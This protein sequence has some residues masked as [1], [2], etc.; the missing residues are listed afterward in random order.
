MPGRAVATARPGKTTSAVRIDDYEAALSMMRHLIALGHRDI[1]FIK[2]DPK[3]TPARLRY[4]AFLDAMREA[5][6]AVPPERVVEGMFTYQSGLAAA[7]TLLEQDQRPSAVFACND[8][9]AAAVL[10]VAHGL[11]LDV[12]EDLAVCGV[13]DTPLATTVWPNLTTVHQPIAEMGQVAVE[14]MCR[15]IRSHRKQEPGVVEHRLLPYKL[16]ARL[17]S[18]A[19]AKRGA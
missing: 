14:L 7:R 15:Q 3:H 11:R 8:D 13:D 18:T 16:V 12:P 6:L 10:A 1:A 5:R 4:R 19:G 17:S 9:L 2:G